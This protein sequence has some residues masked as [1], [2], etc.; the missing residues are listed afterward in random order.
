MRR[1]GLEIENYDENYNE[2]EIIES[3][4][5]EEL[6]S[7]QKSN[8]KYK[9]RKRI[10]NIIFTLVLI[11]L[12]MISI[13]IV[14]VSKYNVGPF[15]AIRTGV[16]K[17]G[18]TKEYCGLGYKV[19]KYHQL[20]GRRDTVIGTWKLQ[21]NSTPIDTSDLD[22]AIEFQNDYN[23]T[24]KKYYKKFVR[25]SS[26]VKEVD[27]KNDRLILEYNDEGNKYTL[28]IVCNM[29]DKDVVGA[30]NKEDT[31]HVIGTIEKFKVKTKKEP[32]RVY[33][34]NCFAESDSSVEVVE[35]EE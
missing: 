14:C 24:S 32:N 5:E 10:I 31:V 16:L 34:S 22:L 9:R 21:Y 20:Q 35:I 23:K 1:K 2:P 26:T 13:D 25:L 4:T 18:G 6:E 19:I 28:D 12:A 15:F 33:I 17:D 3:F 29:A 30:F 27:Y 11:I 8:K 7:I